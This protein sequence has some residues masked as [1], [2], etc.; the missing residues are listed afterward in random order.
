MRLHAKRKLKQC[1]RKLR[2]PKNTDETGYK[3]RW[4]VSELGRGA[5]WKAIRD[6]K[7][8]KDG[9]GVLK[10]EGSITERLWYDARRC[11]ISILEAER[12]L[13][14]RWERE[15]QKRANVLL[16]TMTRRVKSKKEKYRRRTKNLRIGN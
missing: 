3:G 15:L 4:G 6:K 16:H 1:S 5:A 12:S 8:E 14:L 11:R 10:W 9:T 13:V 7:P 2:R